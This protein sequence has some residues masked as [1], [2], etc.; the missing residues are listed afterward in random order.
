[1]PENIDVPREYKDPVVNNH[2]KALEYVDIDKFIARIK[3]YSIQTDF[4]KGELTTD[5]FILLVVR[6]IL[7]ERKVR[8][9]VNHTYYGF[10]FTTKGTFFKF[11]F[12]YK[13]KLQSVF[14]SWQTSTVSRRTKSKT[15]GLPLTRWLWK[16]EIWSGFRGNTRGTVIRLLSQTKN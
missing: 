12:F 4:F 10:D 9:V 11:F 3:F 2:G 8:A 15:T 14:K 7:L 13:P 6:K 5:Q 16:L 1:M